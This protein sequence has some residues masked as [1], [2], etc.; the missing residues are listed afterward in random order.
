MAAGKSAVTPFLTDHRWQEITRE[1]PYFGTILV[2]P[3]RSAGSIVPLDFPSLPEA[4]SLRVLLS[5]SPRLGPSRQL[6]GQ[7]FPGQNLSQSLSLVF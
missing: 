7:R 2:G 1:E 3:S 5:G 6:A 4:L